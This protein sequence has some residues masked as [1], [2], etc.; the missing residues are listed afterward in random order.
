MNLISNIWTKHYDVIVVGGGPA[1]SV[2]ASELI[3]KSNLS[4]LLIEAG[5]ATQWALGGTVRLQ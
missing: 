3:A 5:D 2:V 1:G 4:V